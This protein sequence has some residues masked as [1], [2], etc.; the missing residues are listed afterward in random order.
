MV[1]NAKIA[2]AGVLGSTLDEI[3]AAMPPQS[4]ARVAERSAQ[5][6]AA[7]EGAKARR[8]GAVS[9]PDRSP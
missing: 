2:N 1:A 9:S 7:V 4:R 6:R 8:F 5:L 3:I